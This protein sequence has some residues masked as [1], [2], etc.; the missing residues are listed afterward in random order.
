[1]MS[2]TYCSDDFRLLD[3]LAAEY[4][5]LIILAVQVGDG[6]DEIKRGLGGWRPHYSILVDREGDTAELFGIRGVPMY[7]FVAADGTLAGSLL[8]EAREMP[9]QFQSLLVHILR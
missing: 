7:F 3:G 1:S 5:E 2:C 4:P 8:G 9:G 6:L